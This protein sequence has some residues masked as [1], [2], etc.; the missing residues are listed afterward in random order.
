MKLFISIH[1][2]IIT[3]RDRAEGEG[4]AEGIIGD[5]SWEIKKRESFYLG[6]GISIPYNA[7]IAH[8]N[9]LFDTEIELNKNK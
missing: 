9:G 7:F 4:I 3:I 8:G 6:K 1:N 5:A 2:E